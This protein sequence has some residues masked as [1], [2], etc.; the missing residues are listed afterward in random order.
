MIDKKSNYY[1]KI[2]AIKNTIHYRDIIFNYRTEILI[3]SGIFT[4][5]IISI[6]FWKEGS[7]KI[8]SKIIGVLDES[9]K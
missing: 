6:A 9:R 3:G 2:N 4:T 5:A 7:C 8:N 1:M